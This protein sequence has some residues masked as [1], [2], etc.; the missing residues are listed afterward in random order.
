MIKIDE[1]ME[2]VGGKILF[3]NV[4]LSLQEKERYAILGANGCGKS[5]FLRLLSKE[6]PP[7]YGNITIAKKAILASLK[8]D[9]YLFEHEEAY[10]V[11]LQGYPKLWKTLLEKK[12][13]L[14][15][16]SLDAKQLEK[17]ASLEETLIELEA[18][19]QEAFAHKL[20][21]GLGIAV[22]RHHHPLSS[23]SGGYKLRV[24]LARSLFQR[25][26][27]LLLD[28]PTN[29]LDLDSIRWLEQYLTR[30]FRGLLLFVSHDECFVQKVATSY[31]DIDFGMIKLYKGSYQSFQNI[32]QLFIEQ[33]KEEREA[34]NR[35]RLELKNFIEKWRAKAS[36][37]KQAM[38]RTK[39]LD[40]I[41]YPDDVHSSR[42]YVNF[43][44]KQKK[45]SS[46]KILIVKELEKIYGEQLL[47]SDLHFTLYRG[48]KLALIGP[49]GCGKSTLLNILQGLVP[50]DQGQI[51]FGPNVFSSYFAQELYNMSELTL[52]EW[53]MEASQKSEPPCRKALG[54]FLFPQED[55]FKRCKILSGGELARLALAK[56]YLEESNLLFL[57]EPTNHLD[58]EM[59]QSLAEAVKHFQGSVIFVSH[60]EHFIEHCATRI[61]RLDEN[62]Y[63]DFHGN[64]KE[65]QI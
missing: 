25:P 43:R 45:Q 44:F 30:D 58:L 41:E 60:D 5:T 55:A 32:K 16:P 40:K 6:E 42:K 7:S 3:S 23:F 53:L 22:S 11:I 62:G 37:A 10:Q 48:E 38:S 13:L 64:F 39:L 4:S 1:L 51:S 2:E 19:N 61:L 65:F 50:K 52:L 8:Q 14:Q 28:E 47:F 27:I 18:Y 15:K 54:L 26:D 29:Y 20:L 56:V 12:H 36:K 33:R 24:L 59:R 46:H 17:L 34:T 49:N 35:R 63:I 57:D 31:L 9:Q 21:S